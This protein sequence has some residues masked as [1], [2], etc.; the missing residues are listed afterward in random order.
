M[1]IA[2][3][4]CYVLSFFSFINIISDTSSFQIFLKNIFNLV[5]GIEFI[6]MLLKPNVKN[7]IDVL[8]FLV[9]RHLIIG[10]PTPAGM[11]LCLICIILLYGF[12]FFIKYLRLKDGTFA[13]ATGSDMANNKYF[14]SLRSRESMTGIEEEEE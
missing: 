5:V 10:H 11:L 4:I 7:I 14:F 6:K 13:R 3:C 8:I 1:L 9:A 12:W 2:T